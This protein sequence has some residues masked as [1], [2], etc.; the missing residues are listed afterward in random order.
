MITSANDIKHNKYSK[1][2]EIKESIDDSRYKQSEP[3]D[4]LLS[5]NSPIDFLS[6]GDGS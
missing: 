5:D 3:S 1:N 4:E 2:D 6:V